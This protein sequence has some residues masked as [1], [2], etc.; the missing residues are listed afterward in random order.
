MSTIIVGSKWRSKDKRD[1]H[2]IVTVEEVEQGGTRYER[3][4]YRWVT[5]RSSL[6]SRFVKA[7]EPVEPPS[8]ERT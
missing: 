8:E 7:F 1:P 6:V 4:Y 3:V 5:R 2:R